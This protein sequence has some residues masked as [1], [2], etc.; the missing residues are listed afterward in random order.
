MIL[1]SLHCAANKVQQHTILLKQSLMHQPPP[2]LNMFCGYAFTWK[3]CQFHVMMLSQLEKTILVLR[4]GRD[5]FTWVLS[6]LN[7]ADHFTKALPYSILHAH[8]MTMMGYQFINAGH[9]VVAMLARPVISVLWQLLIL[10][11]LSHFVM[12]WGGMLWITSLHDV[13]VSVCVCLSDST[14]ASYLNHRSSI[15]T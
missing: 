11:I 10:L 3:I 1:Q 2:Y 6:A 15:S 4:H 5:H 13:S 8:C 14:Y 7:L 9:C 12:R